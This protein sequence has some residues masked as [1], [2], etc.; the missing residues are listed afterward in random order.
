[1]ADT[2]T[3]KV[4]GYIPCQIVFDDGRKLAFTGVICA[5]RG[6]GCYELSFPS[7]HAFMSANHKSIRK[8]PEKEGSEALWGGIPGRDY[9][10]HSRL[11]P[12]RAKRK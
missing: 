4:D 12:R 9:E 3:F 8:L 7:A 5:I 1:M 2:Q 10:I 11:M 6:D